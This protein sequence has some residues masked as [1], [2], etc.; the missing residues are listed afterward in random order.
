MERPPGHVFISYVREDSERVD[1]LE[2]EL[3][4]AGL[5]VWRDVNAI[6]PGSDWQLEI[7]K[8]IKSRSVAFIACFSHASQ[9]R[10]VSYQREELVLA[11][12]QIRLRP[13][14]RSWFIPVRF[15]DYE[16]PDYD[17]GAGKTFNNLNRLDLLDGNW[18][19]FNKLLVAL[20]TVLSLESAADRPTAS[21]DTVSVGDQLRLVFLR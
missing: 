15:D 5:S 19:G 18:S 7:R 14:G 1:R 2:L 4:K 17:I 20:A 9:Q 13:P 11:A 16:I 6:G 12:E 8:A 10:D 21:R 3:K